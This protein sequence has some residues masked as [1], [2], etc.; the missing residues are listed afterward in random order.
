M[1][2]GQTSIKMLTVCSRSS[3]KLYIVRYYKQGSLL[4]GHI[5][6]CSKNNQQ[7]KRKKEKEWEPEIECMTKS[8]ELPKY[9]L[10]RIE[11]TGTYKL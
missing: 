1:P 10:Y 6:L 8:C 4:L 9:I 2:W 11:E 3:D 7:G 5:I